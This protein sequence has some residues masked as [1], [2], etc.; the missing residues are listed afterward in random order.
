MQKDK[1]P[2]INVPSGLLEKSPKPFLKW[3]GG[4]RQLLDEIK[5]NL[6]ERF[7]CYYEPFLGGG[8]VFFALEPSHAVI[9]DLNWDVINAYLQIQNHPEE[10]IQSLK[11]YK[12]DQKCFYNARSLDR[13]QKKFSGLSDLKKAARFIYLNRTCYN[14][15]SRVNSRGEFNTPFGRYKNPVICD[16]D[17]IRCISQY[18]NSGRITISCLDFKEAVKRAKKG[19]FIYFDPPYDVIDNHASFTSYN[20]GGFGQ[21]QQKELKEVC[22]GLDKRGV[23]FMLSNSYTAFIKQLYSQFSEIEVKASRNIN[24][25]GKE[26]GPVS[27]ILVRNY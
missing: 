20:R 21:E 14:G 3:A 6:P 26:R 10:L 11:K 15:L 12:N 19:D 25:K 7:N 9:N 1:I 24:S 22:V 4:K 18:L 23:K 17:N 2:D 27:E 8:A 13:N 16:E 5:A